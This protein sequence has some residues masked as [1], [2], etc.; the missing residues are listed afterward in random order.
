MQ[1]RFQSLCGPRKDESFL[2]P[3]LF[4]AGN[5]FVARRL[6]ILQERLPPNRPNLCHYLERFDQ[7]P[8]VLTCWAQVFF[9]IESN[10]WSASVSPVAQSDFH[11]VDSVGAID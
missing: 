9:H 1:M 10:G 3:V 7:Q 2:R 6:V 4:L 11:N 8:R 5:G